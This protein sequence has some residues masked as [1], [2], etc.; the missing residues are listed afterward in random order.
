MQNKK[1]KIYSGKVWND[2][3]GERIQAHG[4]AMFYEDGVYYWYGEDKTHT[5][6]KGKTWTWGIR[7]YSSTD[8]INWKDE[9]HLIPP[10]IDN[11]KSVLHPNR[12]MDRP[13]I[14]KNNQTGKYVCWLKYCDKAHF[15]LL[16]A[17]R[18]KGPY[19][20]VNEFFQPYGMKSGDF[21]LAVDEKT[22]QG[23]LF[24]EVEHKDVIVAKLSPD[25]LSVEDEY[26]KIYEN[27]KPPLMREAVCHFERNGLHYI[28]TSGM[29]GYIPN[30]S[31]VAVA[32]NWMGPYKVLGDPHVN[33]NSSA[34]FNSQ[35]SYVFKCDN[36]DLYIA[37]ADRWVPEFIMDKK[38]YDSL[39]RVIIGSTYDHSV[40]STLKEKLS[41]LKTPIMGSANTSIANY[42]WLPIRFEGEQA[43]IDWKDE[44]NLNE[45]EEIKYEK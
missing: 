16:T 42:V 38:S 43:Y 30:P 23:Y 3:K 6:K 44:W 5:R 32:K 13:H 40:K 9:G 45:Y 31:E 12:R 7:Y 14:I 36:K 33:D 25:Y 18:F 28:V 39:K 27:L 41:I 35:I 29:T 19:T 17:D 26:K 24:A 34:S 21:D 20:I 22:G 2:N 11:K 10:E 4:A 8:L 37:M 1:T 15:V